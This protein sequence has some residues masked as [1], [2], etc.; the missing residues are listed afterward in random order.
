MIR[1]YIPYKSLSIR[2]SFSCFWKMSLDWNTTYIIM[3]IF[4][5]SISFGKVR[6][7]SNFR[8]CRHSAVGA[9]ATAI[10]R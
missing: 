3:R 5:L 7:A 6:F 4:L 2:T 9:E 8:T 10:R 1:N